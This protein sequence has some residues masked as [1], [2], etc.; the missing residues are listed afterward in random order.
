VLGQVRVQVQVQGLAPVRV[1]VGALAPVLEPVKE[2][3]QEPVKVTAPA[4][5]PACRDPTR[6]DPRALFWHRILTATPARLR[7]KLRR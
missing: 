5:S 6:S 7:C 1:R 2:M 4:E 3:A